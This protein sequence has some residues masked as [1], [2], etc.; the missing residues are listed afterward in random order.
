MSLN[1]TLKDFETL[2]KIETLNN[3]YFD[4]NIGYN[5]KYKREEAKQLLL[6]N[7]KKIKQLRDYL[8]NEPYLYNRFDIRISMP[9]KQTN[10]YK[11]GQIRKLI[12][13]SLVPFGLL[14]RVK[15]K[16]HTHQHLP[17]IQI[18]FQPN[19]F[20]ISSIWLHGRYCIQEY[21]D[22]FLNYIVSNPINRKYLI[23]VYDELEDRSYPPRHIQQISKT[24]LKSYREN[25]K[26][27]IGLVH[28]IEPKTT[29]KLNYRLTKIVISE[30]QWFIKEVFSPCF[31]YDV[32]KLKIDLPD[33]EK[34]K[35]KARGKFDII[36]SMRKGTEPTKVSKIHR[37]IQNSLCDIFVNQ[38]GI[39]EENISLEKGFVDIQIENEKTNSVILYEIKTDK[40]ALKCIKSGLGQL[41][42]YSFQNKKENW[43]NIKL[44]IIGRH[45]MTSEAKEFVKSIKEYLG[46]DSFCYQKFDENKKILLEERNS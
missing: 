3:K 34:L 13:I 43:N 33:T 12:W 29:V 20:V 38:F 44:V 35:R 26:Y 15:G 10:Q 32:R 40:T 14:N 41:L 21:R 39:K 6:T 4:K 25:N 24:E 9:N 17:Q 22:Q 42:F 46:K 28:S 37:E 30:L 23:E 16:T 19:K 36:N 45:K 2:K 27:S 31:N 5:P 18:S 8:Y 7:K 1:F 11:P